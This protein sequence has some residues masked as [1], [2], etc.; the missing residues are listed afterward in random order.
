[1]RGL[2]LLVWLLAA[3]GLLPVAAAAD[4]VS[5]LARLRAE[6]ASLVGTARCMNLVQCRIAGL[7]IDACG[8]PAEYLV[9]S[10]MST[11]KAALDT[12][13]AEYNFVQEDL[14]NKQQPAAACVAPPEPVATCI[15]G[16]CVLSGPR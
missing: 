4:A 14:Q 10:W 2:I 7:G 3:P 5:D 12:K 11:D 6:I 15:N 16:R 1:M 13:I 9:Y 8:S